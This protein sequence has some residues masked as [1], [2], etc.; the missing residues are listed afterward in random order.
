MV[1]KYKRN[2]ELKDVSLEVAGW[3][4]CQVNYISGATMA[5]YYYHFIESIS[6]ISDAPGAFV[7][8]YGKSDTRTYM[9]TCGDL[10]GFLSK[11]QSVAQ[12]TLGISVPVKDIAHAPTKD[13][14]VQ[15][16]RNA[17]DESI[18][19][20]LAEFHVQKIAPARHVDPAPR[21]ITLS[22]KW[23]VERN[24]S[25][26]AV[27]TMRPLESI[28]Q[29]E[30]PASDPQGFVV[31]YRDGTRCRYTSTARDALLSCLLD[32][33][34]ATGSREI[35]IVGGAVSAALRLTPVGVPIE[36]AA[37]EQLLNSLAAYSFE[38]HAEE[39][40]RGLGSFMELLRV[41]NANVPYSGL[42]FVETTRSHK[43]VGQALGNV[44]AL[45][46]LKPQTAVFHAVHRLLG[47]RTAFEAFTDN[48]EL[49]ARFLR[50]LR[51]G[52]GAA[53]DEVLVCAALDVLLR[54][55]VPAFPLPPQ[56]P[57]T[58]DSTNK[59]V[60]IAD[61]ELMEAFLTLFGGHVRRD[62]APL[63]VMGC[64]EV[65]TTM[66]CPPY[67][68]TTDEEQFAALLEKVA[69]L[70]R[71][72]F[73]LFHQSYC[74]SVVRGA[75]LIM[76]VIVEEGGA[77]KDLVP[78]MQ[79]S[80][81]VEGATLR[82]LHT[83]LFSKLDTQRQILFKLQSR[84]L[85][86]LWVS[87]CKEAEAM[88]ERA[89]PPALLY[90][91]KSKEDAPDDD[92]EI[93]AALAQKRG[94]SNGSGDAGKKKQN[95]L[96]NAWAS[97]R[98]P[99]FPKRPPSELRL[100]NIA[101]SGS[102]L[103]W[104]MFFYQVRQ[105]HLRA[106]LIWN[107]HTREELREALENELRVFRQE[108]ELAADGYISWNHLEF[109]VPYDCLYRELN[110]G[111]Y[112]LRLLLNPQ[113]G[114]KAP[115]LRNPGE[116]FDMLFHRTL[117]ED[118]GELQALCIQ[119]LTVVYRYYNKDIGP[120]RDIA[121][122]VALLRKCTDRVTRDR[123]LLFFSVLFAVEQNAKLFVD[124]GGITTL[125]DL[126]TLVHFN[127]DHIV[128][129]IESNLITAGAER[130]EG[131]W[132]Y[133]VVTAAQTLP[134]GT[135]VP[136]KKERFG[137]KNMH[138]LRKLFADGVLTPSTLCWAQ[139]MEEWRPLNDIIQLRWP[140]MGTGHSIMS[141][142]ELTKL[143]LDMLTR[144][145]KMY[146]IRD[147][148]GGII[149]PIP[150]PKRQLSSP[151]LLPYVAQ[152]LLTF[153]SELVEK[154]ALLLEIL[155][156]DNAAAIPK[157]YLT[158]MFYFAV[159]YGGSNMLTTF[160]LLKRIHMQQ[161]FRDDADTAA[162]KDVS[163]LSILS[164]LLPPAMVHLLERKTPEEFTAIFLG[165]NDTPEAIWNVSMRN[166]LIDR[167]STHLGNFPQ[168]LAVNPKAVY[169]YVPIAPI[170]YKRLLP[171][172]FCA[173][174]YLRNFCDL[175]R[176]PIWPVDDEVEFLQALL[177][178]WT[179]EK[180]KPPPAMSDEEA[181]SALHLKPG[182]YTEAQL[183]RNYFRLAKE[184]HPDKNPEGKPIFQK[185]TAAYNLL[186][187]Q[188]ASGGGSGGSSSSSGP[189]RIMLLIK[190][191]SILYTR[192]RTELS[193]FK[194][195]GYP[196]LLEAVKKA[197]EADDRELLSAAAE[198][199]YCTIK[200]TSLNAEEMR[201]QDGLKVF[202]EVLHHFVGL[203]MPDT[204][205]GTVV[206]ET[207]SYVLLTYAT[208]A[209]FAKCREDVAEN[210]PTVAAD[211][212]YCATL[213][214]LPK[215]VEGAL[216][217]VCCF[218]LDARLAEQ[219]IANNALYRLVPLLFKY[220]YTMSVT[221]DKSADSGQQ[222]AMN[223]HAQLALMSLARLGGL[224]PAVDKVPPEHAACVRALL[225]DGIAALLYKDNVPD[226]LKKL[227]SNIETPTL[228]WNQSCRNDVL[229]Y[230]EARLHAAS[231]SA[232]S[233]DASPLDAQHFR[234]RTLER[235]LVIGGIYV[236]LYNEQIR[237]QVS[238]PNP[239]GFCVDLAEYIKDNVPR[240]VA[241]VL[242]PS[243]L[244][245]LRDAAAENSG[246]NSYNG[247]SSD[248]LIS[249][250][251]ANDDDDDSDLS[252]EERLERV[253][254]ELARMRLA[255]EALRNILQTPNVDML[256]TKDVYIRG[257]FSMLSV[258]ADP[259]TQSFTLEAIGRLTRNA[260]CIRAIAEVHVLGYMSSVLVNTAPMAVSTAATLT[261]SSMLGNSKVVIDCL[262]YGALLYLLDIIATPLEHG[263]DPA[264]R[265]SA[266]AVLAKMST[267][268]VHGS[269]IRIALSKFLPGVMLTTAKQDAEAA[270]AMFDSI[271]EN[272]E[273]IWTPS[274]REQ[275]KATLDG[276]SR[277]LYA[278]QIADPSAKWALP[279]DYRLVYSEMESQLEIGGVYLNIFLKQPS[280]ALQNPKAFL[281]AMLTRYVD[282]YTQ[283][284]SAPADQEML[285]SIVAATHALLSGTPSLCDY[286]AKT[287]HLAKI[288]SLMAAADVPKQ[289]TANTLLA[290]LA[291]SS[292]CMETMAQT[293]ATVAA[294]V[295]T[296]RAVPEK[297][298]PHGVELFSK[299]FGRTICTPDACLVKQ[300]LECQ[301]AI[302]FLLDILDGKYDMKLATAAAES[303]A[304]VV[305]A[306]QKA[307][308]DD[309]L[310][311][312][313][314][315][316]ELAK[317]P[318]W[319]NYRGMRHDLFLPGQNVTGLLTNGPAGTA[320]RSGGSIGLLTN[321]PHSAQVFSDK[322]PELL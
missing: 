7:L 182:E 129:P 119:A 295:A 292:L 113:P 65:L 124:Y 286:P 172:L 6:P 197:L 228:L 147:A 212:C 156:E 118:E 47:V 271:Q 57:N 74:L 139:G 133:S 87:G 244:K 150:R 282:L 263:V 26:Y 232:D 203:V 304:M 141:D 299:T 265:I 238:L 49:Q 70:G 56:N 67:G 9:F 272:P 206:P 165:N 145:C 10:H 246:G 288:V 105:D 59:R 54:L 44:L 22:D 215:V 209:S 21:L 302:P 163:Q 101:W 92:D 277:D 75:G 186:S 242:P 162:I 175:A 195:A 235:E 200:S 3:G 13:A 25:T 30:R 104:K 80:A 115:V 216:E 121:H 239:K 179:A 20:T 281:E 194:Y 189:N 315:A 107:N 260:E 153:D 220:D 259:P 46:A 110:V 319:A 81:L 53:G 305:S 79:L 207:L 168:R 202:A 318:V 77:I 55:M 309:A 41:F 143:L 183:R 90:Y 114:Q 287:G 106:D 308:D 190:A 94:G 296:M 166:L 221:P 1:K 98:A 273:L 144:L 159:I 201:R 2:G 142:V 222:V 35:V 312:T 148:D 31:S 45:A 158:G 210:T 188:A 185:I 36:A 276:M 84:E 236:R 151:Q 58:T 73:K 33:T 266:F 169:Q 63:V 130:T 137:P 268:L 68:D 16:L 51:G 4:L 138:E 258:A 62:T 275:L 71:D 135:E 37:E 213:A 85:V 152:M 50:L 60:I 146:P 187:Q 250:G 82:H 196:L 279:D 240:V 167:I 125:V 39:R 34:R 112:Y 255:A 66:L 270:L 261:L 248:L 223:V 83:A 108:Q 316:E 257:I 5:T 24:P 155:M 76:K 298:I 214:A 161:H 321:T 122:L 291:T 69:A 303:K 170:V 40:D 14:V 256:L 27:V 224:D 301:D 289:P 233:I 262:A 285:E 43:Q 245:E 42:R 32:C 164:P 247:T 218:A 136:A 204:K 322:P 284:A 103:N 174:Y 86:A 28:D 91:L 251:D 237:A 11:V 48:S 72:F 154:A 126:M 193:P 199:A 61:S 111:G 19:N 29:L 217:S 208:A 198:L 264:P 314:L 274:T 88:L 157:A 38:A 160:R 313:R 293:P 97:W 294:A 300:L 290:I 132:Y 100:R 176:F 181:C 205:P 311:G 278:R 317:S 177:V 211:V 15:T 149:R 52:L 99:N 128:R 140:L 134:D 230:V 93:A 219:L 307:V 249:L 231:A 297:A 89:L 173:H 226:L 180:D 131:E 306:L 12:L 117:L 269:R 17:E 123:L 18:F 310:H 283:G 23:L 96:M 184:Y 320:G 227:N 109:L 178:L 267:D 64:V 241:R 95:A 243:R 127:V 225:S 252:A 8:R 191:Q 171:E 78:K 280:W 116:F 120:F 102:D 253:E 229:T 234:F 192:F 254:N